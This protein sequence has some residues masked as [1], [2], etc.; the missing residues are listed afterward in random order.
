M[1]DALVKCHDE[2][3]RADLNLGLWTFAELPQVGHTLMLYGA[4]ADGKAKDEG[5]SGELP[6]TC[7]R[8]AS[9]SSTVPTRTYGTSRQL[10]TM[11]RV[12]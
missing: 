3:S 11:A 7:P 10:L 9:S 6:S 12:S 5:Y 2:G 1:I 4:F 8:S